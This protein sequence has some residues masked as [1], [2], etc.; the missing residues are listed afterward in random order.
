MQ[1]PF[2]IGSTDPQSTK[3]HSVALSSGPCTSPFKKSS[4][5]AEATDW[6]SQSSSFIKDEIE[7]RNM[8]EWMDEKL[9]FTMYP[10][11]NRTPV[12]RNG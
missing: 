1:I 2:L 12:W 10:G 3:L 5:V 8:N 11:S 7:Y 6:L 4:P 9:D